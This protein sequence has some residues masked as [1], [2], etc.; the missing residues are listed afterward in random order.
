[1]KKQVRQKE[2]VS[3]QQSKLRGDGSKKD[4]IVLEEVRRAPQPTRGGAPT[5]RKP[6]KRGNRDGKG[7][8]AQCFRCGRD[9]PPAGDK[10][11]ALSAVCFKCQ[12]KG[13]FG[14]QC[15]NTRTASASASSL[16]L[17]LDTAFLGAVTSSKSTSAWHVTLTLDDREVSFKLDTGAEVTAISE[18]THKFLKEPQQTK[19]SKRLHGPAHQALD[20]KGQFTATLAHDGH[21][22]TQ[23]IYVVRSLGSNLLGLPAISELHLLRAVGSTETSDEDIREKYKGV[24][25]GLGNLGDEYTIKLKPNVTPY[26]LYTPRN[27]PIPL[28]EKVHDELHRME[29]MGVISPVDDPT[30]WCAGMVVVPKRSGAVRI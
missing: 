6:Y 3:E 9:R 29:S 26:A 10:C 17:S 16:E 12:K 14:A 28:R 22:T 20:V 4:P 11:P 18:Q 21:S 7:S 25:Q 15:L 1:M 27:V 30:P 2:V 19:A 24:F 23:T 8:S 5:K 13:H